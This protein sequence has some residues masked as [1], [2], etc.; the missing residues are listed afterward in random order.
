MAT[1][2]LVRGA[3]EPDTGHKSLGGLW[4]RKSLA[5]KKGW[6]GT[7]RKPLLWRYL[8]CSCP[9]SPHLPGTSP[10]WPALAWLRG[11]PCQALSFPPTMSFHCFQ[12]N[13][14]LTAQ[15]WLL[16]CFSPP[17]T[18]SPMSEGRQERPE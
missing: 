8:V 18:C 1:F 11:A 7:Q 3:S 15:V 10:L 12:N 9:P 14:S 6:E 13:S 4:R 5:A 2:P 16:G 17:G